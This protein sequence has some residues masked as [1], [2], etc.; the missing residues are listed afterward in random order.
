MNIVCIIA[1][2][3]GMQLNRMFKQKGSNTNNIEQIQ[4]K[5]GHDSIDTEKTSK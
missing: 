3:A 4:E 5:V 1:C 2:N